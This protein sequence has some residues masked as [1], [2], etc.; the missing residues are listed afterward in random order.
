MSSEAG[1]RY[2]EDRLYCFACKRQPEHFREVVG[3]YVNLVTPGGALLEPESEK[4]YVD[5]YQCPTCGGTA[6]W[7]RDLHQ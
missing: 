2:E 3:G 4:L 7:G 1:T 5:E 6:T